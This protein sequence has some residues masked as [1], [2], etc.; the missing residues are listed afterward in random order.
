MRASTSHF[1]YFLAIQAIGKIVV[2]HKG[3]NSTNGP[4]ASLAQ[5]ETPMKG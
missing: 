2:M 3:L 1:Q 4:A 5:R